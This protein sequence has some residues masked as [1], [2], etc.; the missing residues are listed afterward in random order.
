MP[1]CKPVNILTLQYSAFCTLVNCHHLYCVES[2][3]LTYNS[4]L[5]QVRRL[6]KRAIRTITFSRY[7]EPSKPLFSML[8]ILP[9]DFVQ[10]LRLATCINNVIRHN[11]PFPISLL[12]TPLRHTRNQT[13]GNLNIPPIKNAYGKR[14][15]QYAGAKVWNGIPHYIKNSENLLRA[16]KNY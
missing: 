15:L 13:F 7:Y 5:E 10:E 12:C 11:E 9:F 3:G 8:K 4:Y 6:Q 1:S 2:W 14:L 16:M